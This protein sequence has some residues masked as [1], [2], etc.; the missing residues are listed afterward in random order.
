M[1]VVRRLRY[2]CGTDRQGGDH[3]ASTGYLVAKSAAVEFEARP[4]PL[5]SALKH[6]DHASSNV[7]IV[8]RARLYRAGICR[9]DGG[10][11][12]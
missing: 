9:N 12:R 3:L 5:T 4:L 1:R 6:E 2:P 11:R 8:V 7:P 10:D